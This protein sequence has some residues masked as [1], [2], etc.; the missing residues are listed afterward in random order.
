MSVTPYQSMQQAGANAPVFSFLS[1]LERQALRHVDKGWSRA[2]QTFVI[3]RCYETLKQRI[4]D[5]QCFFMRNE[6]NISSEKLVKILGIGGSK[7]AI[8]LERGRAL[9]VPNLG[10]FLVMKNDGSEKLKST[11]GDLPFVFK[12]WPRM[13]YEETCMSNLLTKIGLLNPYSERVSLFFSKDSNAPTIPAYL[14]QSFENLSQTQGCFII[15]AKNTSSSTWKMGKDFL[16]GSEEERLIP[17]NWDSVVDSLITDIAKISLY[18]I[19]TGGDSLNVAILK[20]GR[21]HMP[22]PYEIRY[23]GFDFSQKSVRLPIPSTPVEQPDLT[24]ANELLDEVLDI[25][26]AYEFGVRYYFGSPE[27]QQVLTLKD[28]LIQ[29][30]AAAI[31]SRI[32]SLK[33]A[34]RT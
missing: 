18:G 30:H 15:D 26:F 32:A 27:R 13:V 7:M 29:R 20:T 9:I 19:Q 28:Q 4:V 16:F 22:S 10:F 12:G 31:Q 34:Q 6:P 21:S 25:V 33:E 1:P 17:Q 3:Q 11:Q 2:Y 23:F 5:Q 8:Q 24:R 14:S